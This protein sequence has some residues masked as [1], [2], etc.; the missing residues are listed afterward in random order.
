MADSVETLRVDLRTRVKRLADG[1]SSGQKEQ[2][3]AVF[4]HG[5]MW[6]PRGERNFHLGHSVLG[7]RSLGPA[8]GIMNKKKLG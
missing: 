8:N 4:V 2:N 6:P 3:L 7:R 5:S 1:S